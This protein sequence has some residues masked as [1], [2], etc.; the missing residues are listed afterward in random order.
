MHNAHFF[1]KKKVVVP[2]RKNSAQS[3]FIFN[4]GGARGKDSSAQCK[5]SVHCLH[6]DNKEVGE[7]SDTSAPRRRG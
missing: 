3:F 1:F 5:G 7:V 4:A 2:K 6:E